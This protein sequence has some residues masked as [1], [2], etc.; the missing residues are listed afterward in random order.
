MIR[1]ISAVGAALLISPSAW[2]APD[3]PSRSISIIVGFAPGGTTDTLARLV[4]TNLGE[5]LKQTVVVE[6]ASGAGGLIGMQK[7]KNAAPDG[8]TL[9]FNNNSLAILP[10][11]HPN[12][13]Y[14]PIKEVEP[15]GIVAN[16]PMVLSV[17]NK[18]GIKDLPGMLKQ[19]RSGKEKINLGSG[20]PGS[21]A[22][23]A[24]AM[25]LHLSKT[26]GELI[27][28]RG[29]GPALT[30]LMSGMIDGVIDQTVTMLPLHKDGRIK[31]IAVSGP[32]RITQ[33][34]DIPTFAEGG[35][36]EF[37]LTIWNGLVAPKGT[38]PEVIAKLE[39]AL[40]E[41]IDTPAFQDRLAQ[42]AA[43]SP[44]AG[45]RGAKAFSAVLSRDIEVISVLAKQADLL[46]GAK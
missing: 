25:F 4:A 14:D 21:T 13:N 18:S 22:H 26:Q 37:D 32:N 41:V 46:G 6:N 11:L 10:Q 38:P 30:D 8:Y 39:K 7:L 45:A 16:V 27:Q 33:A 44:D 9:V 40:N 36:P 1:F 42:L 23:L 2:A 29:T 31:A 20:G 17:S 24:E 43:Q 19:M 15:I 35:L 34:P 5:K 3:Y 28:Y 12:A